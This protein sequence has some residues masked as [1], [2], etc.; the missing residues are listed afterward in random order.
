MFIFAG[1]DI[2]GPLF[3]DEKSFKLPGLFDGGF[4]A[5]IAV[6]TIAIYTNAGY[7]GT[8][9][10]DKAQV[11]ILVNAPDFKQPGNNGNIYNHCFSIMFAAALC[12]KD[13]HCFDVKNYENDNDLNFFYNPDISPNTYYLILT[14]CY[15]F[16]C[17]EHPSWVR[18]TNVG[19]PRK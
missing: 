10:T 1:L 8:K 5:D 6:K 17:S 11:N 14:Q 18:I 4:S 15:P 9:H 12:D 7:L 19:E 16:C 13:T 3:K 2:A